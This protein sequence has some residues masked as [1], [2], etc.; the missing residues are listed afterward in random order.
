MLQRILEANRRWSERI[1]AR[2]DVD[3]Y[4]QYD[5]DVAASIGALADGSAVVDLGGGRGCSFAHLVD[6][7]R[8]TRILAVDVSAEELAANNQV[9]EVHVAD[10]SRGLPFPPGSVDLIVSRTLLEHVG[11]VR[12]AVRHMGDSLAPGGTTLHLVPCRYALFAIVAQVIP[13][14]LAKR[15]LHI[16][17]PESRGVVEFE[18]FY[19]QCH[20]AAIERALSDAGFCAIEIRC[21]WDQ[22]DY[23][24][25][26]F[27]LFI[28]V[29][30]Y[31]R[32][33]ER[34]NIRL[35][36]SYMIIRANQP[37]M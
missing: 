15:I 9:D 20:P 21:T 12:S 29:Y 31:Q 37:P 1:D 13:F 2:K 28:I 24:K 30:G 4:R 18:V 14:G 32:A 10:V 8:G 7:T 5:E 16:L 19:D 27:P 3:L 6:R 22:S 34:L 36:A 26:I 33:V 17:I 11:D 25:A 23:F 35:L